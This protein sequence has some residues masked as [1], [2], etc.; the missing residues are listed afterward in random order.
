[1]NREWHKQHKMPSG[2]TAEQR[3]E[4][5]LDHAKNCACRPFPQGLLGKLSE[6]DRQ[7]VAQASTRRSGARSAAVN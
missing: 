5:H 1:M 7:R 6:A 2:A 3:V 4:W